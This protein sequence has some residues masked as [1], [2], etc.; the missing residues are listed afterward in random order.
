MEVV[1][2]I[3]VCFDPNAIPGSVW[4]SFFLLLLYFSKTLQIFLMLT[5]SAFKGKTR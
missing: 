3:L 4:Y 5:I 1:N 2:L